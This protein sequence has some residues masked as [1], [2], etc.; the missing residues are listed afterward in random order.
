MRSANSQYVIG[1]R[2]RIQ[3]GTL[4][5]GVTAS[6]SSPAGTRVRLGIRIWV[7]LFALALPAA[8]QSS[9][10]APPTIVPG[11]RTGSFYAQTVAAI[12]TAPIT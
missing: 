11:A 8:A 3:G 5:S 7:C 2:D 12:G 4:E 6:L 9:S 1:V 10:A